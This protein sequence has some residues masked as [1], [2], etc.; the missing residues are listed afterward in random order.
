MQATHTADLNLDHFPITLSS[1]AKT[2]S[3][4]PQLKHKALI[5]LG[6]FCDS[7]F[8]CKLTATA[9]YLLKGTTQTKIGTRDSFTKLW[10]M[11]KADTYDPALAPLPLQ[12]N[13]AY[14]QKS[15]RDLVVYLHQAA[16]SPVPSTWIAAIDAGFFT[17]WP[18]LTADL[19]RKH[20]PKSVATS[21]GH[22]RKTKMNIRSTKTTAPAAASK[23][24]TP[25]EMTSTHDR[26]SVVHFKPMQITGKIS[27]DQMGR[28]PHTSSNGTKYIMACHVHDTNGI[29]TE[30][31]KSRDDKELTR[32]FTVIHEYLVSRGL[33][34]KVQLLDNECPPGLQRYMRQHQIAYQ[35]VPPHDHRS[36]PAEKAIGTWKD[37]FIS[38]LSSANPQFPLHLWDRLVKQATTTL[39]LLRRSN[40]NP[41]LSAEAHLNGAF[42]FNK[43]PMAP[44]GTKVLV[45][46]TPAVRGSWAP[47]GVEGWYVGHAPQHYRCYRCYIPKTR[48]ERISRSVEFFPHSTPMPA[49]SSADAATDAARELTAAL[50]NPAPASPFPSLGTEQMAAIKQLAAIFH[51]ATAAKPTFLVK[52]APT[53][54][55]APTPAPPL[56][57]KQSLAQAPS[58]PLVHKPSARAIRFQNRQ[59]RANATPLPSTR[60]HRIPSPA[61]P[62]TTVPAQPPRVSPPSSPFGTPSPRPPEPILWPLPRVP[63]PTA[64]APLPD[65]P[66]LIPPDCDAPF[67]LPGRR[68]A[69]PLNRPFNSMQ[70]RY[71]AAT[72]HLLH[73][74]ILANSV[75]DDATGLSLEYAAL[76]RGPDKDKWITSLANDF[77]RLAQGVGHRI[78]GNNTMFFIRP[79]KIPQGRK[80]TYLRLVSTIRPNKAEQ[81]RVR[82][83]VGGDRLEYVGSTTT[84]MASLT[85]TKCLLN[86]VLSTPNARF[87]DADIANFYYRTPLDIYEYAQMP[88][89]LIPQEII[90]EYNL[91]DVAVNGIVYIEIRKGMP[92]LK[93]AGKIAND[94]LTTHLARHGYH[95]VPHTPALW[96]HTTNSVYF[97]LV[98]DD[99][100]IK[101]T[102][103]ADAD[104]LLQALKQQ[105]DITFD[106]EGKKYLGV[107]LDWDYVNRTVTLSMPKY[108]EAA[109]HK[110][111]HPKPP[112]KQ[113]A[114]HRWNIPSYGAK[115]QFAPTEDDHPLLDPASRTR[116]QKIVGMFLYY[117]LAIDNTMLV[118]LGT[119]AGQ[120][121]NPTTATMAA[122]DWLLDYA[123]TH[124]LAK[125]RY[126]TSGMQL[127]AHSDA[128][129]LSEAHARSRA[130]GYYYLSDKP[131]DP[132]LPPATPPPLNG[133]LHVV[134]KIMRNVL[135]SAAEAEIAAAYLTARESVPIRTTLAELGHPQSPTPIQV[136]N[137]TCAGFAN[138]TIKQ[139]RTKSIDMNY[140]WLQD[141]TR[142]GQFLVY[143]RAGCTNYADYHT[144]HHSPTH[145]LQERPTYLYEDKFALT[146]LIVQ[147]L[148]RGCDNNSPHPR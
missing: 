21:K 85:T 35:L 57:H 84:R 72:T 41:Q 77:G 34:P 113:H 142:L 88:L 90:H 147:R 6:Q 106:W 17:T 46:E 61:R 107:D 26:T 144:K 116:V 56:A 74:E 129:Y 45:H 146:N 136:D 76:S 16:F 24:F 111:Q 10:S 40:T 140:Y 68:S 39:N 128:S 47:H 114:P 120:Q 51:V 78:K 118:A 132:T 5:S 83:T 105:Y 123:A 69:P 122:A 54:S 58:P 48:A 115:I 52:L 66:H 29:L 27:T 9:V 96:K 75:I 119:I 60:L 50:L 3:V 121:A 15:L 2:S 102:N 44:P 94:R 126:T 70:G 138:D 38:G 37:H 53:P 134:S 67:T 32:A 112:R 131:L 104:H 135:G 23:N 103:K 13:N 133:A 1:S 59:R 91:I 124:P 79:T 36:N 95:P 62:R 92:G 80:V 97:T 42:D 86:S 98:V 55:P 82:I 89:K 101:Y 145:H 108:V 93:Q 117:A 31:L 125:L 7:G 63:T 33:T 73:A 127:Y 109:L 8:D 143:W 19:V 81:N 71:I 49:T 14:T 28:F 148:Q 25:A 99:F 87:M 130:A 141:R 43:T 11:D 65:A 4:F 139:K 30:C 20:L 137:T 12:A 64:H 22:M 100:G 18:G 110:L